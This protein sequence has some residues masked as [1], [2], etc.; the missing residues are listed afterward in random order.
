MNKVP[1]VMEDSGESRRLVRV[2]FLSRFLE[3]EML[4]EMRDFIP[5]SPRVLRDP[6]RRFRE[7]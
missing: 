1:Q 2:K 7:H 5:S 4:S 3:S 6:Q